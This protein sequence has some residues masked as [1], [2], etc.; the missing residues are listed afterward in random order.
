MLRYDFDRIYPS[1][2]VRPENVLTRGAKGAVRR[3]ADRFVG[4]VEGRSR[5]TRTHAQGHRVRVK[6]A[7]G[8]T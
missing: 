1:A 4:V 6:K 5:G 3:S 7:R 8:R 2:P